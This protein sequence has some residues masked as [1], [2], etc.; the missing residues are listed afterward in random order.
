MGFEGNVG[1]LNK[2]VAGAVDIAVAYNGDAIQAIAENPGISFSNPHEGTVV[3]VDSMCIPAD[4]PNPALAM[5]FINYI[6]D[7]EIGAQ[8]SNFNQFATPNKPPCP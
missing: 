4:A 8:L 5:K 7:A 1:G 3:W 2:V 6:L